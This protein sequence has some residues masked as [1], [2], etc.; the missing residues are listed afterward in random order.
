MS[1]R[2]RFLARQFARPR[3]WVGRRLIAPWLNR[4]SRKET[5]LALERLEARA[6]ERILEIGFGGGALL[7]ALV[8]AGARPTGADV[9]PAMTSRARRRFSGRAEIVDASVAALPFAAGTFDKAVSV[10]SLYFWEN[11]RAAFGE[12]ARVLR[13]GGRVVLV[14]ESPERLRRWP[15]H[16]Y[17][18]SV[19]DRTNA[20]GVASDSGFS[21]IRTDVEAGFLCLT[22]ERCGAESA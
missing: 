5:G 6:G 17:G 1:L 22:A 10:N 15:G 19:V 18:F 20:S 2:L 16:V 12:I 11:L 7:A 3:G 14:W 13:P 21:N 4:I 9:S 8:A